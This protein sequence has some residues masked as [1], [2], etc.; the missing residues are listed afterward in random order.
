MNFSNA[1][2]DIIG[3]AMLVMVTAIPVTLALFA[4]S[5]V[6]RTARRTFKIK[7]T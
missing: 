1:I 5:M 2:F 6:V 7:R 3:V 4:L